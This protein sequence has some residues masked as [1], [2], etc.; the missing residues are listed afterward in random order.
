M[1]TVRMTMAVA[2]V[3]REFLSDPAQ[4]RYGYELMSHTR[5]P[6]GKL[7][8]VLARLVDAGWLVRERE[9]IDASQAGRPVRYLYRLTEQG[10]VAA[11]RE[12]SGL[13]E[14]LAPPTHP[15]SQLFPDR[16]RT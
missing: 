7:Y 2:R 15:R 9:E 13:S 16:M 8:P 6:S 4:A 11:E 14:Q 5:F 3:L 12:L 10:A 1:A